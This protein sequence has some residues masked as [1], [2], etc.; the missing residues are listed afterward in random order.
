M[1]GAPEHLRVLFGDDPST[2]TFDPRGR[3]LLILPLNPYRTLF[4]EAEA[5]LFDDAIQ[6]LRSILISR[7]LKLDNDLTVL[8]VSDLSQAFRVQT[9]YLD[10]NGGSGVGFVTYLTQ[11]IE[12]F[13]SSR[14]IYTFQGLTNDGRYYIAAYFP[15]S[16]TVLTP[17]PTDVTKEERDAAR[18]DF[19]NYYE[20]IVTALEQSPDSYTPSLT[21]FDATIQSLQLGSDLLAM[22]A[23]TPTP[24][25]TSPTLVATGEATEL[26]NIRSGPSTRFR[27][28]G[29]LGAGETAQL[30]DRSDDA[31]WVR[32]RLQDGETGWVNSA[33]LETATDL[34]TL[35]VVP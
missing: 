32:I 3:Q 26:L 20:R 34:E 28:V 29:Q 14:L 4:N 10:F 22:R 5:K 8:P 17:A 30:I 7:P 21:A 24:A 35:P 13:V 11:E 6:T 27:V 31:R 9:R 18:K 2:D 16:S 23:P 25:S 19:P 1:N 12:P 33:Y 15:I